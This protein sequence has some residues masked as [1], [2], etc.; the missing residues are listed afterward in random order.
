MYLTEE[1]ARKKICPEGRSSTVIATAILELKGS[2]NPVYN[3]FVEVGMNCL[4]SECPSWRPVPV[5]YETL[6]I[7]GKD[8][9]FTVPVYSE[10]GRGYCG[11]GGKP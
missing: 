10:G 5:R 6:Q 8:S 3:Q 1:E 4:A 7:D 2:N 9:C 11:R